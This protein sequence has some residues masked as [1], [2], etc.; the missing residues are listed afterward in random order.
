MG[1][2]LAVD[3][4]GAGLVVG[5]RDGLAEDDAVALGCWPE[6]T[7]LND[8]GENSTTTTARQMTSAS[9]ARATPRL[10]TTDPPLRRLLA[11]AY[12]I[13]TAETVREDGSHEGFSMLIAVI[14]TGHVGLVSCATLAHL[15][16]DVVGIDTD[17]EKVAL[18]ERGEAPF[19]EPGLQALLDETIASGRLRFSSDVADA[20]AA[21][22]VFICVGTPPKASGEANLAAVESAARDV[23]R[24]ATRPAVLVEKSTVP[25]GTAKRL[26]LTIRR[27]RPDLDL[28]VASNPEFLREG[29]GIEDSLNPDRILVGAE[30]DRAFDVLR[31]VYAPLIEKGCRWIETDIATAELSKHACNAFLAMKIS[32]AN[33]L[34]RMCELAGADIRSVTEVMGSDPRI[35]SA[36][37]GAGIG[38]GGYCFPKDIQAFERLAARLGYEFPLL[39]EVA[40][41]NDEAVDAVVQKVEEAVWNLDGKRV[42]LFGLAFKPG[43]DDVRLAPAL[44]VA[45]KLLEH[46]TE[47]VGYDPKAGANAKSELAELRIVEDPYE[48]ASGAHCVVVCTEW[49]ELKDIDL[50][51][52]RT[53]MAY[54]V[55]VD[56]RNVFEPSAMAA[57]G[58]TYI[59]TGR[60][61][62][63]QDLRR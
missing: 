23:A 11:I 17:A 35:G 3:G 49:D 63:V 41:I 45:R 1:E 43:T 60:P 46:G 12:T 59:P 52:L 8:P 34:A 18:L 42:A 55:I 47:V 14:G 38:Y 40:R 39:R 4:V 13:P 2:G 28:E 57:A 21:E 37:L 53:V 50:E 58:F 19:F 48:A 51:Q 33:A 32:Y 20:A 56:G 62:I 54:P 29:K 44:T 7:P 9:D 61:A 27:E 30:S 25:A 10:R 15:G 26:Q 36:F 31:A 5:G 16:H 22:V 24:V 6:A